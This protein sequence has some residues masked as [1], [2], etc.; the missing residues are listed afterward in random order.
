MNIA[1]IH[2]THY[3]LYRMLQKELYNFEKIIYYKLIQRTYTVN[4]EGFWRWYITLFLN[5]T[6]L[7]FFHRFTTQKFNNLTIKI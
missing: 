6:F 2:S 5:F 1:K 4:F 7:D 3:Q